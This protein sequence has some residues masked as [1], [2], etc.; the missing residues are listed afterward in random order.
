MFI[1]IKHKGYPNNAL[2]TVNPTRWKYRDTIKVQVTEVQQFFHNIK[3][4]FDKLIVLI[5][6]KIR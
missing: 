5:T 2:I 6:C 4:F 1:L 3:E